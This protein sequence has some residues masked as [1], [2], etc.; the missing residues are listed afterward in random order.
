MLPRFPYVLAAVIFH[1]ALLKTQTLYSAKRGVWLHAKSPLISPA[2]SEVWMR[3]FIE[4]LSNQH[5]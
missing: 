4:V 1:L 5:F 3:S 2:F